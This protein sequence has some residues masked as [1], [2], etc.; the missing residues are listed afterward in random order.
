M[1][2]A[3]PVVCSAEITSFV[4]LLLLCSVTD[5]VATL[6]VRT[7][8]NF[9]VFGATVSCGG[10]GL[11]VDVAGGG[12]GGGSLYRRSSSVSR[13]GGCASRRGCRCRGC[14]RRGWSGSI[15][16]R[17]CRRGG[18]GRRRGLSGGSG[19]R[20]GRSGGRRRRGGI[21]R[22][23]CRRSGSLGGRSCGRSRRRS[24]GRGWRR[25]R[26]ERTDVACVA[27]ITGPRVAALI[28]RRAIGNRHCVN[29]GA[30]WLQ[31]ERVCLSAV[32]LER[33]EQRQDAVA[34]RVAIEA[35]AAAETAGI[36]V[37]DVEGAVSDRARTLHP[38]IGAGAVGENRVHNFDG[39]AVGENRGAC[40]HGAVVRERAAGHG[41]AVTS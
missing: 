25:A 9:T 30:V 8:L 7:F 40:P 37:G 4:V 38:A 35:G 16:R 15:G 29:R 26:F 19:R 27:A 36:I 6:P 33:V 32:I 24:C 41:P 31:R 21:G 39:R 5:F 17:R 10:F 20:I 3:C 22:G 18:V 1:L 28:G 23:R 13:R 12:G 11:G 14:R 34:D 2:K